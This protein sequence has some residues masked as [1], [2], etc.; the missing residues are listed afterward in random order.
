[1]STCVVLCTVLS[2]GFYKFL[3]GEEVVENDGV[4]FD[5]MVTWI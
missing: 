1:M 2:A 3:L 4:I 5:F